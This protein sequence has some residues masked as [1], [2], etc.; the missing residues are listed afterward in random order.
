MVTLIANIVPEL[1]LHRCSAL[2]RMFYWQEIFDVSFD[3]FKIL[4]LW[5]LVWFF[6]PGLV[7]IA[8]VLNVSDSANS[9][10]VLNFKCFVRKTWWYGLKIMLVFSGRMGCESAWIS[11]FDLEWLLIRRIIKETL[12][13]CSCTNILC[14]PVDFVHQRTIS[15]VAG[16]EDKWSAAFSF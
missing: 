14:V 3:I 12:F 5:G 8:H 10:W 1:T 6:V 2:M 15:N 13:S 4:D 11:C 9:S 7:G 16:K